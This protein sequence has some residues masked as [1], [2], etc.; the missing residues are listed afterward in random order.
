M[1]TVI[2]AI[3]TVIVSFILA[4]I[5]IQAGWDL[6]VGPYIGIGAVFALIDIATDRND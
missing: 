4:A 6:G 3:I 1:R 5:D 2:F